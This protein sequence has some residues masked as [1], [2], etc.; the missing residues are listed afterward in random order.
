[1][2]KISPINLV[3]FTSYGAEKC[4]IERFIMPHSTPSHI[5]QIL[6]ILQHQ[7]R[8]DL[9]RLHSDTP[10]HQADRTNNIHNSSLPYKLIVRSLSEG[11]HDYRALPDKSTKFFTGLP[12]VLLVIFSLG[13]LLNSHWFSL[14]SPKHVDDVIRRDM[15]SFF[16]VICKNIHLLHLI[17]CRMTRRVQIY[18]CQY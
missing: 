18:I 11:F 3:C 4:A 6:D 1:M 10:Q 15:S 17:R 12:K 16:F 13:A 9:N 5:I 14:Y 8:Q 2:S 7:M